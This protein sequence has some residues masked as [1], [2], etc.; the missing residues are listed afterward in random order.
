MASSSSF[1]PSI[2]ATNATYCYLDLDIDDHRSNFALTA[3]FVNATD[4]R[5]GLSSPDLLNL[6]G[7]ELARLPDLMRSDHEWS[8]K[9]ASSS[10]TIVTKAPEPPSGNRLIVQLDWETAPLACENFATL[11][12][13]G[14]GDRSFVD[15]HVAAGAKKTIVP[16]APIGESGK[17]LTYRGSSIH[18]VVP[19][20]VMQGGDF[21]FGN[22]T[23][24]ECVFDKKKSFKDE[25]AG[26]LKKHNQRGLLSMGNSGKNSNTSQFFFT[27]GHALPQCDGKHV[28]FGKLVSGMDLLDF[29]EQQQQ[30]Q[31]GGDNDGTP[32]QSIVITDCGIWT[33][34][35]TPAAGY[36]Y[37][38]PD[39]DSY[40]GKSPVLIVRPR[41]TVVA[42]NAAALQKFHQV[43]AASCV[44]VA[45]IIITDV[46]DDKDDDDDDS[47]NK[48]GRSIQ[49]M[50]EEFG[51]DVVLVAPACKQTVLKAITQLP[52]SWTK[53]LPD[54]SLEQVVMDAKPVEALTCVRQQS[55]L[56]QKTWTLD[57]VPL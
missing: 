33:P 5:Y 7:S 45:S 37:D 27:F 54:L 25:R 42:P 56:A 57:G 11:C 17:P 48:K 32:S 4:T 3:A 1:P 20:F 18:R 2:T 34:L 31:G 29:I 40:S 13:N 21:V 53:R 51:T 9:L 30:Q 43:L 36:W 38:K 46:A 50:L 49:S 14:G 16:P 24:G 47:N 28:I 35:A 52:E 19:G 10:T 39:A 22:G 8:S 23:G 12:A 26:L 55:W 15:Q 41:V 44:V 6:G